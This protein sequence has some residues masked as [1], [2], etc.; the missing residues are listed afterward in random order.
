MLDSSGGVGQSF[1][2][3][4]EGWASAG[5]VN[6][7]NGF[8]FCNH[9]FVTHVNRGQAVDF[10]LEPLVRDSDCG[11]RLLLRDPPEQVR[12]WHVLPDG[13]LEVGKKVLRVRMRGLPDGRTGSLQLD[14][15]ALFNGDDVSR[16]VDRRVV[17]AVPL[18]AK[19]HE[20]TVPLMHS[21]TPAEGKRYLTLRFSGKG[22]VEIEFCHIDDGIVRTTP[23]SA[24]KS[25]AAKL[26]TGFRRTAPTAPGEDSSDSDEVLIENAPI[27]VPS[28]E[29]EGATR[30]AN[31]P[32][33][34]PRPAAVPTGSNLL[35]NSTFKKWSKNRPDHWKISVPGG[36]S[37]KRAAASSDQPFETAY[38]SFVVDK[39]ASNQS[40]SIV[41]SIAT[42]VARQFLDI[43]IV[44][45]AA[46]RTVVEVHL[47]A[48]TGRTIGNS[49]ATI[50]LWPRWHFRT[51]RIALPS[52]V[53]DAELGLALVI[54]GGQALSINLAFVG[55]GSATEDIASEFEWRELPSVDS[56]AVVNGKFD[57]WSGH[58]KRFLST[59]RTELTDDWLHVSKSPS[60][61]VEARLTEIW[62]RGLRDGSDHAAVLGLA[63]HGEAV[64]GFFR[65]Q[66]SL[67]AL[68]ILMGPPRQLRFYARTSATRRPDA[69]V[70]Q[71]RS[72][73]QQVFVA[74]RRRVSPDSQEFDVKRLFSIKR[75]LRIGRIAELHALDLR[76]DHRLLLLSKAKEIAHGLDA[77]LLLIFEFV[78]HIDVAIGDV[79]FG[80]SA[81]NLVTASAPAINEVAIEDPN[82]ATQ[83]PLLK[84][85]DH[86]LVPRAL[87]SA[88]YSPRAALADQ[89]RWNWLPE[90][91]LTV[92]IVVCVHNAIEETLGCLA[93]LSHHTTIPHTVSII[94]DKSNES[95]REQLRRYVLGK[96]WIRLFENETN[97]G[98]TRSANIGL[99]SSSAEWTVLLNS[100]TIVTPGWLEGMFEV[101]KARP[102]V[103]MVGPLSNAASWQSVPELHDIKGG[104]SINPLPEGFSPSDVARLVSELSLREFPEATLLNGFCTLMRRDVVEEVGYLDEAAF[105]MGYGEENDLCLRVRKAGYLLALADHVYVYHVKSA[106]FGKARRSELSKRGT[107]QLLAK[108]PDVDM[109]VIQREM[110]ELTSLLELRKKL[111]RKLRKEVTDVALD[112]GEG[113]SKAVP[114][115]LVSYQVH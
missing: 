115:G 4:F 87:S 42:P 29:F 105:P 6:P 82:I 71:E 15:I 69:S 114:P 60:P 112:R 54:Q 11:A 86:W 70:H 22:V 7:K 40:I 107:A 61:G 90:S 21:G 52:K 31:G 1:N 89:G 111:R 50:T 75:N 45:Q 72:I 106:S 84:G 8:R 81:S 27:V 68:Q 79:Y 20:F 12:M 102:N 9:W 10:A 101:V 25:L 23:L 2:S 18:N 55:A 46:T 26:L 51:A 78:G 83:L 64:G 97:L 43:A 59:R 91:K 74:E 93:S 53:T 14:S 32:V 104:W 57:H 73:V 98:Y 16:K 100:D 103:A 17:S 49:K 66:A 76:P 19:W 85:V 62:P 28:A 30:K 108:H 58:V 94:N 63:M 34:P 38:L 3:R 88:A 47:V 41:Q 56:N 110:A 13:L 24:A 92:D 109:K 35:H 33:L 80:N 95:T 48:V 39:P 99:S 44:G 5:V 77:S 36:V 65:I 37:F 67:D 96:P 113:V